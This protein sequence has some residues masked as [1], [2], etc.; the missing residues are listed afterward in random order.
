VS[1]STKR[2]ANCCAVLVAVLVCTFSSGTRAGDLPT[3]AP[4]I[5]KVAPGV[6]KVEVIVRTGQPPAPAETVSSQAAASPDDAP[7]QRSAGRRNPAWRRKS[8]ESGVI[9]NASAGLIV[10]NQHV[11]AQ[12]DRIVV[13]LNDGRRLRATPVGADQEADLA[14]I[15]IPAENL[16]DIPLGDSDKV[17]VGDYAL[18][19]GYPFD[20]GQTASL[21]IVSAVHRSGLGFGPHEDFLQTDAPANPGDAGGALLNLRGELIGLNTAV[22]GSGPN[23]GIS[24]AIPVNLVRTV[25]EQIAKYGE[26]PAPRNLPDK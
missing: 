21:G 12:A 7:V 15:R 5:D 22:Y 11:I 25:A 17:L 6:V 16:T 20:V 2:V 3:L 23:I 18:A 14:V 4:I 24:F 13:T 9:F 1:Q 19:I 10:V 26:V 8:A